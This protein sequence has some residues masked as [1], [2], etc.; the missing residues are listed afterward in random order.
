MPN[1]LTLARQNLLNPVSASRRHGSAL[2]E[3]VLVIFLIG[4][5]LVTGMGS[6]SYAQKLSRRHQY[7]AT[8]D[9]LASEELERLR[10]TGYAALAA[11]GTHNLTPA[12]A[13]RL[14]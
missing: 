1:F 2:I 10:L 3:L 9:S 12:V 6:F 13:S 14:N 8:A 4:S 7:R 5:A 11:V